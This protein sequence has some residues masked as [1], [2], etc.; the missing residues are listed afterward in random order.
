M[1]LATAGGISFSSAFPKENYTA[2]F[3][4][5]GAISGIGCTV[6]KMALLSVFGGGAEAMN[7]II[8]SFYLICCGFFVLTVRL[9]KMFEKTEYS[10]THI[11]R[12]EGKLITNIDKI[13][14]LEMSVINKCDFMEHENSTAGSRLTDFN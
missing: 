8:I 7:R 1:Q 14:Q 4:T 9:I 10:V 2:L 13:D 11:T 5:G 3:F 6:V 12:I